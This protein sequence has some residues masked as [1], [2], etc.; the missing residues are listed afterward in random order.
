VI[1][2]PVLAEAQASEVVE[3]WIVRIVDGDQPARGC[4]A[5]VSGSSTAGVCGGGR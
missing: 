5:F 2:M 1:E 4:S 3:A